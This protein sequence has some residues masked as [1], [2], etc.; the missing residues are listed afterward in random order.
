M[1]ESLLVRCGVVQRT[2]PAS[3]FVGHESHGHT[4]ADRPLI[5][6]VCPFI[7]PGLIYV[8]TI[9]SCVMW[10]QSLQAANYLNIK[11]LLDLTC[12]TVANMI[13]GA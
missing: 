11:T 3:H 9:V 6:T 7:S 13:K 1:S 5:Q 10:R 2:E 12:M 4:Q 8:L